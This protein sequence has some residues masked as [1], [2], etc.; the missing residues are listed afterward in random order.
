MKNTISLETIRNALTAT[1]AFLITSV[2]CVYLYSRYIEEPYLSYTPLP[3]PMLAEKVYPGGVATATATRCNT[4]SKPLSYQS[5]RQIKRENSNEPAVILD[6]VW[7]TIEPGC[8]SV[9]TRVNVV[10]ENNALGFYRFSGVAVIKG[11]MV[12]HQVV[13]N[14]DVF[15]V[16]AKPPIA[17][18]AAIAAPATPGTPATPLVLP[19]AN[20]VVK[21]EVKK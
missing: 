6:A 19:I 1:L 5:T 16:I 12:E 9:S 15:E 4:T 21:I 7:I 11:L 20:A 18:P 3:F 17:A 14:T 10:P 13:W 2:L 8:S